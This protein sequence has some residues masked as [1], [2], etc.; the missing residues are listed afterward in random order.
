[1][2][3]LNNKGFAVSGIIYS[4]LILFVVLLLGILSVLASNKFLLDKTK[5][6]LMSKLNG[7]T[8]TKPKIIINRNLGGTNAEYYNGVDSL[9]SGYIAVG[10][11]FSTNGDLTGITNRGVNDAIIVK[12][13]LNGNIV[14]VKNYGGSGADVFNSVA[15]VSDGFIVV[16]ESAST[17]GDLVGLNKG[18]V[19]AII[20]KYDTSGNVV[21]KKNY[22]GSGNENFKHVVVVGDGYVVVGGSN[23][24]DSDLVGFNKGL[25]DAIIVKY[26][27]SGNVVWKKNFGGTNNEYFNKVVVSSDGYAAVG[28]SQSTDGN[29]GSGINRGGNDG[30][31]AKYDTSGNLEWNR[32]Y[33]GNGF[34]S[35]H[36]IVA[37]DYGYI[38]IGE[39]ASTDGDLAGLNKGG[40]DAIFVG[41]N[42]DGAIYGNRKNYGGTANDYFT[43]I[44][45]TSD[46]YMVVGNSHSTDGDLT[47]LNKGESDAIIVKYNLNLNLT[48][49]TTYGGTGFDFYKDIAL[50]GNDYIMA[51]YSNSVDGDLTGLSNGDNDCII[52]RYN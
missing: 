44:V 8:I 32:N 34:D 40:V 25:N 46:G 13:D 33:G 4:I 12:H 37:N 5:N 2:V 50:V 27:T 18:G 3:K 39:A 24:T 38:A 23:S 19:D 41:Y 48:W 9:S 22:G 21:W 30:I 15:A 43:D 16:G 26:D 49:K 14:W 35:Y 1:M 47:G 42:L 20:V 45:K 11:S 7:E 31:I 10:T 36:G 28:T 52:V 29:L 17:T 51:G 6:D